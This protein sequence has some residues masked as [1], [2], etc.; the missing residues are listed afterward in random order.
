MPPLPSRRALTRALAAVLLACSAHA[1]RAQQTTTP[2][3]PT[4]ATPAAAPTPFRVGLLVAD[5]KNLSIDDVRRED[6][7]VTLG[8]VEQAVSL[9]ARDESPVSLGL[10]V[11]NS[12][13]LRTLIGAVVTAAQTFVR[14]LRPGDEAFVVRFV[15]SDQIKLLHDFTSDRAALERAL[16]EMVVEGG[17]T[18]IFDALHLSAEHLAAKGKADG[19][20]RRALVLISDGDDRSSFYKPEQVLGRLRELD[21]Q[22]FGIGLPGAVGPTR[23]LI[24]KSAKEK[25]ED[26]LKQ[27]AR[28][29]GG[30]VFFP[31]TGEELK[32]ALVEVILNLRGRYVVEFVPAGRDGRPASGRIEIKVSNAPGRPDRQT[33]HR[34]WVF[35]KGEPEVKK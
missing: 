8:G 10:V 18:A 13:S 22:V 32:A 4:A 30:R 26:L 1:L 33:F 31:E 11:D 23:R 12:G 9:F 28:E 15:S 6:V 3:T 16:G 7:R 2:A 17:Q 29:T 5:A 27:L 34:P 19:P 25:A 14:N 35:K 24:S 20:R 21:V